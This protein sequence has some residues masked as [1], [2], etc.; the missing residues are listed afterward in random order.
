[1]GLLDDLND[2]NKL[3]SQLRGRCAVCTLIST[4][5]K[6][7][8]TRL[9]ELMADPTIIRARLISILKSN[10]YKIHDNTLARHIRGECFGS[11]R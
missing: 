5:D 9:Q 11:Q 6:E 7:T 1:M 2:P 8:A 4:L 10:G 3:Q